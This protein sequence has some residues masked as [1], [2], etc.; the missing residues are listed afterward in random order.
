MT[1]NNELVVTAKQKLV[2]NI[3]ASAYTVLC[4]VVLLIVG[5]GIID[6]LTIKNMALP[7]ILLTVGMVFLTTAIIQKNSVSLWLSFVFLVPS[8]VS[9]LANFTSLTYGQL[10]PLYIAIPGICSLGTLPLVGPNKDLLRTAIF[11][12][13]LGGIFA[14]RSSGLLGWEVVL[15][16]LLVFV[17]LLIAYVAIAT[18]RSVNRD[19]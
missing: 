8:V 10:Y 13:L 15:P 19:E 6:G 5:L 7:T 4:G 16:I 1:E 11:F 18:K 12:G 17:G 3:I 14:L 9:Y 2:G